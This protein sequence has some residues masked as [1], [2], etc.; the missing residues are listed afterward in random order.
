MMGHNA[1]IAIKESLT[2]GGLSHLIMSHILT[3]LWCKEVGDDV[4]LIITNWIFKDLA[5][6]NGHIEW[7]LIN[8]KSKKTRKKP[9]KEWWLGFMNL[10]LRWKMK[11]LNKK[12]KKKNI[13]NKQS[14]HNSKTTIKN[15]KFSL[16]KLPVQN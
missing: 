6:N 15:H 3:K 13:K 14:N 16:K 8:L 4:A 5:A 10:L 1:I 9:S 7:M 2:L 11:K 12:I